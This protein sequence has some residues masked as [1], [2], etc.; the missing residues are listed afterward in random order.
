MN[1]YNQFRSHPWNLHQS[2]SPDTA[3][4]HRQDIDA[5]TILAQLSIEPDAGAGK[6]HTITLTQY[7]RSPSRFGLTARNESD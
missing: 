1:A 3:T 4:T 6:V 5:T 7:R 2:P